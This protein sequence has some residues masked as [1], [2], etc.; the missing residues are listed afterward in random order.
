[1]LSS[2]NNAFTNLSFDRFWSLDGYFR[3]KSGCALLVT[4]FIFFLILALLIYQL[5]NVFSIDT[6]T[7]NKETTY[8]S[9]PP[10]TSVNTFGVSGSDSYMM[11]LNVINNNCTSNTSISV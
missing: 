1:M 5:V 3:Q 6:I 10:L 4:L 8:S 7:Y 9:E 11:G 2:G